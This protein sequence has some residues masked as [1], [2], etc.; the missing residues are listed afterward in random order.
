MPEHVCLMRQSLMVCLL[1]GSWPHGANLF[2]L[3]EFGGTGRDRLDI[4]AGER[5]HLFLSLDLWPRG[6]HNVRLGT[7]DR[8]GLVGSHNNPSYPWY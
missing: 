7:L 3:M 6:A 4:F 1:M 5:N 2:A 8:F